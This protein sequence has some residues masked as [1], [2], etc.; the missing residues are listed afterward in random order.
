MVPLDH[1]VSQVFKAS[2]VHL[3]PQALLDLLV[4]IAVISQIQSQHWMEMDCLVQ[5]DQEGRLDPLGCQ[6]KEVQQEK[7][8]L[9]ECQVIWE[10]LVKMEHQD[11][12]VHQDRGDNQEFMVFQG[13]Q[14][15]VLQNLN[16][17]TYAQ[18]FF[19]TS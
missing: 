18:Q 14:D 7:E 10:S 6:E 11:C 5:Q 16:S 13:H 12:Q 4:L 1:L 8:D 3:V 19:E 17:G 9:K 2:L 15:A